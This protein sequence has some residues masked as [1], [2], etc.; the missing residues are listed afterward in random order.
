[1]P[2][3]VRNRR[4]DF[5]SRIL[6][7]LPRRSDG[8]TISLPPAPAQMPRMKPPAHPDDMGVVT[9]FFNIGRGEW[10][11]NNGHP[12]YLHRTT[13]TYVERFGHLATLDNEMVIYTSEELIPRVRKLRK[14]KEDKTTVIPVSLADTFPEWREAIRRVQNSPAFRSN[15]NPHQLR[16]PEYWSPDYVMVTNLKVFFVAHA[17]QNNL[18]SNAQAAWIDFGYCRGIETLGGYSRWRHSFARDKIHLFTFDRYRNRPPVNDVVAN[19]IVCVCG[20]ALVAQRDLWPEMASLTTKAINELIDD[21]MVDD[22]QTVWYMAS[23]YRPE[24]FEL[25][26]ITD[27]DWFPVIRTFNAA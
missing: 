26:E 6:K 14:G 10:T 16:N 19:N 11:E 3:S 23:L 12:W 7:C 18:F 4:R 17:V 21:N 9:A 22:D 5:V 25:N 13:D 27:D 20:A 24:L 2:Q 15:I 8:L 1:M